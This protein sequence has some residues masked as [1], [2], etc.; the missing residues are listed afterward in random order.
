MRLVDDWHHILKR[1]WSVRLIVIAGLLTAAEYFAPDLPSYISL[2]PRA[3]PLITG[4]V[5]G[6]AFVA[7][8]VA[9]KKAGGNDE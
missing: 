4:V 6:A 9:Q 3:Y 7:R 1:A 5:V 2:P 8:L